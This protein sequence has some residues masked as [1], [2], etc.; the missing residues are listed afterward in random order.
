MKI[1]NTKEDELTIIRFLRFRNLNPNVH[2]FT[3]MALKDIAKHLG[4]S[5]AYVSTM[6][7]RIKD[8]YKNL[9]GTK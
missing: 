1:K 5:V 2:R 8:E 7:K 4:R 9:E 6:C 3:F